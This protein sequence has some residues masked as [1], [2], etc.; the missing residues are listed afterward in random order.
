MTINEHVPLT[1]RFSPVPRSKDD[2]DQQEIR[3][4]LGYQPYKDWTE[5]D[6]EYRSVILAEAGA[7]KTYEMLA[8]A[9]YV[10]GQGRPAFCICIEDIVGDFERDF[11]VGSAE[12][13]ERW[14]DSQ[15]EAWFYLDSVDEAPARQSENVRKGY[16]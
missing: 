2:S 1:R 9:K 11:L 6:S 3:S 4:V 10:E 15:N 8:R 16:S 14:L 7:G 5:I 13:F 12:S